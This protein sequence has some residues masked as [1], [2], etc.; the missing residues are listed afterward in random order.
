VTELA[1]VLAGPWP[2][3]DRQLSLLTK[4]P[5]AEY[6]AERER[7]GMPSGPGLINVPCPYCGA[8]ELRPCRIRGTGQSIRGFHPAR[9]EA[10][11]SEGDL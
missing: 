1:K 10:C 6:L 4:P 5:T 3:V 2:G 7:L 8:A 9:V 11:E